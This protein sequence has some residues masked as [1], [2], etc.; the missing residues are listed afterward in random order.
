VE[1]NRETITSEMT[2]IVKVGQIPIRD[3]K[4]RD[5]QEYANEANQIDARSL[6]GKFD[7]SM[8]GTTTSL[9]T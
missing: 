9:L 3:C 2:V 7:W 4:M 8:N 6:S 5:N 1:R